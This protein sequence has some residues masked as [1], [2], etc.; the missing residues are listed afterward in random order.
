[1]TGCIH[2]DDAPTQMKGKHRKHLISVVIPTYNRA[3]QLVDSIK[4]VLAQTYR[5]FEIVVVD[6]GSSD[7]T[8]DAVRAVVSQTSKG[9]GPFPQVRYFYQTNRGQSVARN[10]GVSEAVGDWIAFLDSDDRWLPDKLE[11]QIRA[12]KEFGENCGACFTDAKLMDREGLDTTAFRRVGKQFTEDIGLIEDAV[13]PLAAAFGSTWIQTL[14]VRKD[15]IHKIGGFDGA[16][17]FAEDYDFLFRLSLITRYCYVNKPL[18]VI[19]RTTAMTD[20]TVASRN[21]DRVDFRLSGLQYMYEKWLQLATEYPEDVRKIINCHLRGVHS[22]WTNW[23]LENKQFNK[24][25]RAV[26]T[27]M[28][29]QI[30]PQLAIKWVLTWIAPRI[31]RSIAPK[32]SAML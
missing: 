30:T 16:L 6:D 4:S 17:H 20:P 25:R 24:A 10:N 9:V 13:R 7:S 19:D 15:L 2:T 18:A 3:A 8:E 14:I 22:G 23:Y 29:Y 28:S 12:I 32:S 21:W 31:A 11:W 27:A 26:S 1:M 5:E